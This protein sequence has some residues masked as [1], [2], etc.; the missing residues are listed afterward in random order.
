M[1]TPL[2][3]THRAPVRTPYWRV[4]Y[5]PKHTPL[6]MVYQQHFYVFAHTASVEVS[7]TPG[8]HV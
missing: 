5:Y 1:A 6:C 4:K 3:P 2:P 8:V 7:V